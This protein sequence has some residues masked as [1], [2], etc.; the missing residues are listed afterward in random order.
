MGKKILDSKL[1]YALL[2]IVIAVALWFYVAA[3]ENNTDDITIKGIPI[4]FVNE[5]VLEERGMMI[6]NG[7][8]Q[9]ATLKLTG[10]M[11]ELAKLDQEK[12]KI[13]LTIDVSKITSPGEQTMAFDLDL[14]SAY[15]SNVTIQDWSPKNITFTVSRQIKKEI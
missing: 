14:P 13:N 1:L 2:A 7:R 9:D 12:E 15:D 3:V 8:N 10:P 11:I 5:E 4:T 6:S